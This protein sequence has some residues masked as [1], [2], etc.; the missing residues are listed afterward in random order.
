MDALDGPVLLQAVAG[1]I[2]A[3]YL[4]VSGAANVRL[5]GPR[6]AQLTGDGVDLVYNRAGAQ[7]KAKLKPDTY[8][9]TDP[10]KVADRGRVFYRGREDVYAFEVISDN[11]TREPGWMLHSRADELLYYFLVLDHTEEE[12]AALAAEPDDVL[13]SELRVDRDEL[14]ILPMQRLRAWVEESFEDYTPRPVTVGDRVAWYRLIPRGDIERAVSG[15]TVVGSVFPR[16][17]PAP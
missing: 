15:I 12:V 17:Q 2:V 6:L 16:I 8:F 3:R 13:F 5:V 10:V 4:E 9:G 7:V 1:R 11:A 14:R